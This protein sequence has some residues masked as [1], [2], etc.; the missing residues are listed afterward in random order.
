MV[1][2]SSS[3]INDALIIHNLVVVVLVVLLD[4]VLFSCL[5]VFPAIESP[6]IT[7]MAIAMRTMM[8]TKQRSV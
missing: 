6:I 1:I 5:G 8:N 3:N 4:T 7:I 2:W